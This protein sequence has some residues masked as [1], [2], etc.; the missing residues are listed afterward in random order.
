MLGHSSALART[1]SDLQTANAPILAHL[2][3]ETELDRVALC[4]ARLRR[5]IALMHHELAL[6]R[7]GKDAR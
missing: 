5:G 4:E 7:A 1:R 6:E 2:R 3:G